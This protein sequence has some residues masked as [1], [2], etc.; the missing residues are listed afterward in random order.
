VAVHG[1][2]ADDVLR[3]EAGDGA[4]DGGG[5]A[6][7]LANLAGEFAGEADVLG[8]SHQGQGLC[9]FL[10]G[11][12]I[13]EGGLFK[14]GGEALTKCAVEDGVTGSVGEVGEDDGVFV[15]EFGGVGRV[16]VEVC[17]ARG[18][19]DDGGDENEDA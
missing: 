15:G 16:E 9:D 10:I 14:L 19:E 11:E 13:E 5:T 4:F 17:G 6:G 8:L 1:V 2:D 3:A 12:E 18:D 7:A